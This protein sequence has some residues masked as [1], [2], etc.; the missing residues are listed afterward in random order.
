MNDKD[1][2]ECMDYLMHLCCASLNV[3]K[4]NVLSINRKGKLPL[5][6][7][8][9]SYILYFESGIKD[10][11]KQFSYKEI[12]KYLNNRDHSTII[13]SIRQASSIIKYKQDGIENYDWI[14]EKFKNYI[15]DVPNAPSDEV[16]LIKYIK[17]LKENYDN[18]E[19]EFKEEI[20]KYVQGNRA[21]LETASTKDK[22][23]KIANNSAI[24]VY[25]S[26]EKYIKELEIL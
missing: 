18:K 13:N 19:S 15:E 6:R 8:I 10:R 21:K 3:R 7:H 24:F 17:E 22:D 4:D 26:I 9:F 12:G 5:A 23:V 20:L 11:K 25:K 16:S 14:L 2:L 1:K